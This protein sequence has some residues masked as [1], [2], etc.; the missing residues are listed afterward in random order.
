MGCKSTLGAFIQGKGCQSTLGAFIQGKGCQSTL[1]RL[2]DDC[3][4]ALDKHEYVA[5]VPMDLSKAF[6]CIPH[7]MLL[8]KIQA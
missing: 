8:V 3:R 1:P 2:V 4:G 5:A 7:D 6:D